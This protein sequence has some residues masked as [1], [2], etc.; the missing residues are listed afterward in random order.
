MAVRCFARKSMGI[1]PARTCRASVEAVLLALVTMS[2]ALL[3]ALLPLLQIAT[4]SLQI[5]FTITRLWVS[6]SIDHAPI[7]IKNSNSM[8]F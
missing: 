5:V 2:K 1:C 8:H 4:I 7:T 6:I 3:C